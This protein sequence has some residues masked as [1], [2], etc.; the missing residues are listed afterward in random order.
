MALAATALFSA[1]WVSRG[2]PAHA[3]VTA[4]PGTGIDVVYVA[5]GTNFPDS[6]GVGPG[7]G[8]NGAP[9]IIVP[10]DPP[11]PAPTQAE[12]VRLDPKRVV[13]VG[14]TAVVSVA[15]ETA[16]GALL[17]NATIDR[18]AGANR[19]E[20]NALFSQSVFP[21]EGWVSL[22]PSAFTTEDPA[23]TLITATSAQGT[24][25]LFAPVELPHLAEIL[26]L[27][28]VGLDNDAGGGG[29]PAGNDLYVGLFRQ[30]GDSTEEIVSFISS[31]TPGEFTQSTL[32]VTTEQVNNA[33]WSYFIFVFG[34][35]GDPV[36]RQV[37]VRYRLGAK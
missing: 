2:Q 16:L 10:T 22:H 7:G 33:A 12:L 28:V 14:G 23:D 35:D 18:I 21:V 5:V 26:E 25:P 3:G 4:P 31:G 11:I 8:V 1:V 36:V 27:K 19:Y 6:L 9:I 24:A 15:M 32:L 13:I 20:T 29:Y 17:P 37:M 30:S 34:A